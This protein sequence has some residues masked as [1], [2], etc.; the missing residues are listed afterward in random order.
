MKSESRSVRGWKHVQP[1]TDPERISWHLS[2]GNQA[3]ANIV[4]LAALTRMTNQTE[5]K[6]LMVQIT[7]SHFFT[8]FE[9]LLY[10]NM[11]RMLGERGRVDPAV[12]R[13]VTE[14]Y[15][16]DTYGAPSGEDVNLGYHLSL[17]QILNIDP[18]PQQLQ[19]AIS[20]LQRRFAMREAERKAATRKNSDT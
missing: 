3:I 16:V 7:P 1:V 13:Q 5:A 20:L 4:V 2:W 17:D 19:D 12:L 9:V 10:E 15:T 18:T 11:A 14:E 8:P 6:Q